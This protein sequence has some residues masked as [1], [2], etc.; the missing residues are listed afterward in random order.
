M[1]DFLLYLVTVAAI[2]G[3]LAISLNLQAGVT[4]LLNFGHVA[5]FGVGAY[6]TGIVALHGGHW[7]LGVLVGIVAAAVLGAAVGRIGRTLAADYWAI[8]TLA[9]A[10]CLRLIATN[11]TE[12]TGGAQG[13]GGIAGPFT[14]LS[15]TAASIGWIVTALGLLAAGWWLAERLTAIQFGR[16]L[17]LLRE[18]PLLAES[19]GHNVTGAKVRLLMIAAPIAAVGGSV[20]TMYISFIGPNQLLPIETFLIFTML[21]VGGMGNTSGAILGALAVQLVYTGTR[22]IKDY[23]PIPAESAGSIRL[24]LIGVMLTAFLMFKPSGLIPERL[25]R[26]DARH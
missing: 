8:V 3:L 7:V 15:T 9:I 20:Y 26:V 23:L 11:E 25:R 14:G 17:R 19:L 18:Q 2:Y 1:L 12:L 10:E 4:G 6:A 21:I 13:I 22:F 16:V 24:L 5:F